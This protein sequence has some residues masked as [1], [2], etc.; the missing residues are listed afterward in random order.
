MSIATMSVTL[1]LNT[2]QFS[3]QIT[4]AT[5]Q[6]RTFNSTI[7]ATSGGFQKMQRSS[8]SFIASLRD[9]M[10]ILGQ[11]RAAMHTLWA[12]SGQWIGQIITA[13]AQLERLQALMMGVS[14]ASTA[15]GRQLEAEQGL[16]YVIETAKNAPFALGELANSFVKLKSA[17][18]DPTT[19]AMDALTNSVAAFG[20]DDQIFHRATIAI[21]QMAGKGVISMEELRQ[22]LGEAVPDA[23]KL[24]AR[25]T[26]MT[27]AELVKAISTGTV[28]SG[29]A[30]QRLFDEM[31]IKHAGAAKNMMNT[32][33]GLI[34]Q[35]KTE[36]LLFASEVGGDPTDEDSMFGAAK[37][38]LK[39]FLELLR[40]PEGR[41]AARELGSALAEVI[42]TIL[43]MT[44]F[45]I[46][47]KDAFIQWGKIA[48][49]AFVGFKLAPIVGQ[50][51]SLAS[52][53]AGALVQ[54]RSLAVVAPR[55]GL[56]ISALGGPIGIAVGAI[57]A[58]G[59]AFWDH[60][61]AAEAAQKA[62]AKFYETVQNGTTAPAEEGLR[63]AE[64]QLER[65]RKEM[66]HIEAL[67]QTTGRG[68]NAARNFAVMRGN[69]LLRSIGWDEAEGPEALEKIRSDIASAYNVV[70]Q[71]V[72]KG[73][74]LLDNENT[75]RG[76]SA[77]IGNLGAGSQAA[78]DRL[79]IELNR[80]GEA[81]GKTMTQAEASTARVAAINDAYGEIVSSLMSKREVI[82]DEMRRNRETLETADPQG[83]AIRG[84]A[85][86]T[87]A[88]NE[89]IA[90]RDRMVQNA[91]QGTEL[92]STP[93]KPIDEQIKENRL[94]LFLAQTN[95]K[96]AELE[97][98]ATGAIPSVAKFLELLD[99]GAYGKNPDMGIAKQIEEALTKW[100][101]LEQKAKDAKSVT[102]AF[103]ALEGINAR[104]T[105]DLQT[106]RD[107]ASGDVYSEMSRGIAG[108]ERQVAALR[109]TFKGSNEDMEKFEATVAAIRQQIAQTDMVNFTEQLT[110]LG[111]RA[112]EAVME[113]AEA[114]RM[115]M[116]RQVS[117][118]GAQMEQILSQYEENSAERIAIEKLFYETR[119][120]LEAEHLHSSRT[121]W[122]RWI[123]DYRDITDEIDGAWANALDSITDSIMNMVETG[124][125]SFKDL[126]SSILKEIARIM[127]AKVVAQFA[128]F[129]INMFSGGGGMGGTKSGVSAPQGYGSGAG[130]FPMGKSMPSNTA[131]GGASAAIGKSVQE[132]GVKNNPSNIS[133][134]I[135]N[136]TKE[137]VAA[138][139][140]GRRFNGQQMILDVVLS[141][142]SR[143]GK[144][145]DGLKGAVS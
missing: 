94:Q 31:N 141:A 40:S 95:A 99:Q 121:A 128:E 114:S 17:G 15:A 90:A 27:M 101:E 97:S 65:I 98:G 74:D 47:N 102:D 41:E 130:M 66:D 113:P 107:G 67:S 109:L 132:T 100:E 25:S 133:V 103:A 42:K 54:G 35:L 44:K 51:S 78:M 81:L 56:A 2:N 3:S 136:Q 37:N 106:A 88:I 83:P 91:Q 33:V 4:Y 64:G 111:A 92:L 68:R 108:F 57:A 105:A 45:V 135:I 80:V 124:K 71:S 75:D 112:R 143:P 76:L 6:V 20:G 104:A 14:S 53:I 49:M 79:D 32:W 24:L 123:D 131:L 52:A 69:A 87:R 129:M 93:K 86:V 72:Q 43:S 30:L 127:T 116:N 23:M 140:T 84:Y 125:F 55:I 122:Q 26:N 21:Q 11:F 7:G 59:L 36:W 70:Q 16:D 28:A 120:S 138:E 19:G 34:S 126:A 48:A 89:A 119:Q 22:Q 142:A 117:Q 9:G 12:F 96:I 145:R 85:A 8:Q 73:N 110:E 58:L 134:N 29:D 60:V 62:L 77:W 118:L 63:A 139:E 115:A 137:D 13:N 61:R 82:E 1:D 38:G 18:I 39:E 10:V 50:F 46:Q 144:F 5:G